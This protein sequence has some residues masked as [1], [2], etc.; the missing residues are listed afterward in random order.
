[1]KTYIWNDHWNTFGGGEVYAAS[2]ARVFA[3]LGHE[4]FLV[5]RKSSPLLEINSRL[6]V[7]LHDVK[8]LRIRDE[9]DL[10]GFVNPDDIFINASFGS[11]YRSPTRRSA[12]VCHFP[13]KD[14]FVSIR[15]VFSQLDPSVLLDSNGALVAPMDGRFLL[16]GSGA[17][18][19]KKTTPVN[20]KCLFGQVEISD[21]SGKITKLQA[22][23]EQTF[24]GAS[25]ITIKSSKEL[26]AI[27]MVAPSEYAV[28]PISDIFNR[29][30]ASF[31]T[32]SYG[33]IWANSKFTQKHIERRWGSGS[34][35][36]YPPFQKI[37]PNESRREK[38]R[39]VSVGRFINPGT[40]HCK[41]QHLLVDSFKILNSLSD[42]PWELFLIGGVDRRGE[43]Y[44]NEVLR[45][46][47][48]LELNIKFLPNLGKKELDEILYSSSYYWHGGGIG[49]PSR[50][51][52]FMEHFGISI[53]ESI[54]A[55]IVPLVFDSAGP[56]EILS[57]F[58]TLRYRDIEDLARNTERISHLDIEEMLTGLK[59]VSDKYS[60]DAFEA[61][62]KKAF[63]R[64]LAN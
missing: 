28:S 63:Q 48:A 64:L 59:A 62:V 54:S 37:A 19:P 2:L 12:Y 7:D 21:T 56:A 57:E 35:V 30:S 27:T 25:S 6:G 31:F 17:F 33:E 39:I 29:F 1:L 44:F 52:E 26:L 10:N 47:G 5:G 18:L 15:R 40:G 3:D 38:Y 51:P 8:F 43:R 4:V 55:G 20:L 36:I 58:P 41:N 9:S 42:C 22:N 53:V 50:K 60:Y 11:K 46:A 14:N 49:V 24:N 23:Q 32:K 16:I 61:N 34:S 13:F 45:K